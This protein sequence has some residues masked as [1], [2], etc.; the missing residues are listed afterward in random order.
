MSRLT[1]CLT[2]SFSTELREFI[3]I[4][5]TSEHRIIAEDE[6]VKIFPQF[7]ESFVAQVIT[8]DDL[9]KYLATYVFNVFIANIFV[10]EYS[11]T[12]NPHF[13]IITFPGNRKMN[14]KHLNF[15][16]VRI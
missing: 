4:Y 6:R 5:H 14:Y 8:K 10:A 11:S 3:K 7:H 2:P 9:D 15:V 1:S 13:I 16:Q 12:I